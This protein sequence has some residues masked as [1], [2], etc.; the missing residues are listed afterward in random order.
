MAGLCSRSI[1]KYGKKV[2]KCLS[3]DF[4][5]SNMLDDLWQLLP[6]TRHTD[7]SLFNV[8]DKLYLLEESAG[9][10]KMEQARISFKNGP[11]SASF[12]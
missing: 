3:Q 4:S 9:Y 6:P 5:N 11:S 12:C 8:R 10:F 1:V 2:F 7:W